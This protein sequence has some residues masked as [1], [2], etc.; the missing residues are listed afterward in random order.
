M[1][2]ATVSKTVKLLLAPLIAD[3][4][5]RTLKKMIADLDAPEWA[6]GPWDWS[7]YVPTDVRALWPK[8]SL[9]SRA[10]ARVVASYLR[11]V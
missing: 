2:K 1:S 10:A 8:M 11:E 7:F 6:S 9:E 4:G 5:G 3:R